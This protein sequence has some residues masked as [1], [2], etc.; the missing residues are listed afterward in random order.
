MQQVRRQRFCVRPSGGVPD[1]ASRTVRESLSGQL[2]SAANSEQF[3]RVTRCSYPSCPRYPSSPSS[4]SSPGYP[5]V[6]IY[7]TAVHDRV[8]FTGSTTCRDMK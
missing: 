2:F 4:P 5:S 3:A 7:V 1:K 8:F 6:P